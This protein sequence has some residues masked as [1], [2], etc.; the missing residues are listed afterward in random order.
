MFFIE[1]KKTE[2]ENTNNVNNNNNGNKP[3]MFDM[4]NESL[5]NLENSTLSTNIIK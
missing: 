1:E 5:I 4:F 3:E 2:E